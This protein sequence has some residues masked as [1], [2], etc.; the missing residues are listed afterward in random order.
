MVHGQW[1]YV[2]SVMHWSAQYSTLYTSKDCT[3]SEFSFSPAEHWVGQACDNNPLSCKWMKPIQKKMLRVDKYTMQKY[4]CTAHWFKKKLI[5]IFY[6]LKLYYLTTTSC[7]L[8]EARAVLLFPASWWVR[9]SAMA[10][11]GSSITHTQLQRCRATPSDPT[12][13]K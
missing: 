13:C 5:G 8:Q 9:G 3:N 1:T 4:L 10:P 6:I 2:R 12:T 11:K 7:D